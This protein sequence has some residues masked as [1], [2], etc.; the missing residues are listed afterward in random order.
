MDMGESLVGAYLRHVERCEVVTY[1]NFHGTQG[2]IDV[3]GVKAAPKARSKPTVFICEVT[4]HI[5]GMN[6]RGAGRERTVTSVQQKFARMQEFAREIYPGHQHRFQWWS[7]R[8]P[9]GMLT[10]ALDTAPGTADL[11]WIR[12]EQYAE[13]VRQLVEEAKRNS[14]TT[15]E[16][17]FRMLQILAH[18]KGG[19][20]KL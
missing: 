20:L 13:C 11:E 7:P 2:E 18:L 1:N 9:E 5:K 16:P 14:G 3:V 6:I 10:T 4:T 8:V 15:G 19:R 17:A 12:N